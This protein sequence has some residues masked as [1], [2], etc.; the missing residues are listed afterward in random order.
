MRDA[1]RRRGVILPVMLMILILLGVLAAGFA[2]QVH[3]DNSSMNAVS[4]RFQTRLAAEAGIEKV[5]LMLRTQRDNVDAWYNNPDELNRIIV[6]TPEGEQDETLLASKEE[7]DEGTFAYRFTIVAD[8]AFDDEERCRYGITD[9]SAKLNINTATR[10]QLM[11]LVGQIATEE[12]IVEELVDALLDWRDE[13]DEPREFGADAEYY[14]SLE[15]PYRPKNGAFDTVE[16]LLMVRGFDGR[17]LYGEDYDRNGLLGPNEDDGE[18][19]FPLDDADGRLNRGLYPYITAVSREFNTDTENRP[20]IYLNGDPAQLREQLAEV[21]EDSAKVEF[22]VN[23]VSGGGQA[24][25]EGSEQTEEPEEGGEE[26]Q[27]DEG[28]ESEAG[29]GSDQQ[30]DGAEDGEAGL[31]L[32]SRA[33]AIS[34]ARGRGEQPDQ[35]QEQDPGERRR[36]GRRGGRGGQGGRTTGGASGGAGDG[37][38]GE[39]TSTG[40]VEEGGGGGSFT[41]APTS[42]PAASLSSPADLLDPNVGGDTQTNPL[43]LEDLPI[44]MDR[45]TTVDPVLDQPGLINIMTAPPQ[46]LG[47]LTE[48]SG[49]D[50]TAIVQARRE[51]SEETRATTAWL[52][53]MEVISFET[54]QQVAPFITV[55]GRQ[56]TI[57]SIG[58]ADHVGAVS[59]LQVVVEMRGS[60]AQ[61]LYY[62][63]LTKL[64]AVFPIRE[65]EEEYGFGGFDG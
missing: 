19:S 55:R 27:K 12:M 37:G 7:L 40:G 35:G 54:Y 47:C 25:G 8:D 24:A 42:Q 59:R 3:A 18:E 15:T 5:L 11:R 13:D 14:A 23:A 28:P 16:E 50:I 58:Y 10:E 51:L 20:R 33:Q 63:D 53:T 32:D 61:V 65:N 34:P 56:F 6:W 45:T 17:V 26:G 60:L 21:F 38:Q 29:E 1:L 36:G 57:E 46:V 49:E 64:G 4:L 44:L 39:P 9:E 31:K 43:T 30:D 41:E 22:I 48:L 62:R 2:F 52:A